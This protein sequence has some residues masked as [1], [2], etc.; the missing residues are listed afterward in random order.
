MYGE[1]SFLLPSVIVDQP[2][3][4]DHNHHVIGS[5]LVKGSVLCVHKIRIRHPDAVHHK[6]A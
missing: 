4:H 3:W 6:V 2:S 5:D 1:I